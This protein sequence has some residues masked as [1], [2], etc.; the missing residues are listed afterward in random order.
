[1]RKIIL[2]ESQLKHIIKE[3]AHKVLSNFYANNKISEKYTIKEVKY[4]HPSGEKLPNGSH[5]Q[6]G[7]FLKECRE[8]INSFIL[9]EGI[10]SIQ[11]GLSKYRG[12]IIVFAINVNAIQMSNNKIINGIKQFV[13]TLKNRFNKDKNVHNTITNFNNDKSRNNGEYIGAYSLGNFFKGKYVGDNGEMFNDKSICLEINGL[14]SKSLLKLAE[15]I[16]DKFKQETVLVKDLNY[17]KIYLANS[18]E[19]DD[20]FE[21]DLKKVNTEV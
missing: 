7:G 3:A 15:M 14:S 10:H 17:N 20:S 1:M 9:D 4:F 13:E 12:G 18:N 16:A 6:K 19:S 21:D 11:Y 2:R 5:Y 8:N